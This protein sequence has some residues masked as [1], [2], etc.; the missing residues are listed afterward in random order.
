MVCLQLLRADIW[1]SVVY[2]RLLVAGMSIRG[3]SAANC[4]RDVSLWSV[5][6]SFEQIWQYVVCLRLLVTGMS[7]CGLS[8]AVLEQ[9]RQSVVCLELFGADTAICG[10]S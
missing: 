4:N 6:S 2:L 7:I 5:F 3:L 1:R 9:I 8:S 10:L